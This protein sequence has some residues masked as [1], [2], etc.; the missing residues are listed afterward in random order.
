MDKQADINETADKKLTYLDS[1]FDQALLGFAERGGEHGG[2]TTAACYGYQAMKALLRSRGV[3]DDI[4]YAKLTAACNTPGVLILYK[5]SR[6][7][8]WDFVVEN[9]LHRWELLDRAVAGI[10]RYPGKDFAVV[11]SRPNSALV[12]AS[13][14]RWSSDNGVGDGLGL[15]SGSMLDHTVVPVY[16]GAKTPWFMTPVR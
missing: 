14:Q 9:R 8:I 13:A 16:L 5:I 2:V 12:L 1:E 15:Q 6:N 11:Y 3:N 7:A 4:M 10:G